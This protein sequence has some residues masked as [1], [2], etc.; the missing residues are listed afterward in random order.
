MACKVVQEQPIFLWDFYVY[1]GTHYIC[2][3]FGWVGVAEE[4]AIHGQ[5]EN[6]F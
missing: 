1:V 5:D 4:R 2:L 6:M 3:I